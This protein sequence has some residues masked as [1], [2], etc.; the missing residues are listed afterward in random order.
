MDGG[1]ASTHEPKYSK[2]IERNKLFVSGLNWSLT[3]DE[4]RDIFKPF[5]ELH[6]VRLATKQN[7]Q[8]RGFAYVEYVDPKCAGA[9]VVGCNEKEYKGR[10]IQV[11]I[12][13]P[14]KRPG[15]G[16]GP[17][18]GPG[19]GPGGPR[20][21]SVA[22]GAAP[23]G[24]TKRPAFA[25]VSAT[26]FK[27]RA[28]VVRRRPGLGFSSSAAAKKSAAPATGTASET[29]ASAPGDGQSS[30]SESGSGG[31]SNA[32]FASLFSGKK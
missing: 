12:S 29:T 26:S 27:P 14:P 28:S 13:N 24:R 23:T 25:T 30:S 11:A 9:A 17:P 4:I 22:G 10:R 20:G 15:G 1:S 7:G 31:K 5:G 18:G 8:S 3:E 19:G 2:G 21:G 16:S 6:D 32:F